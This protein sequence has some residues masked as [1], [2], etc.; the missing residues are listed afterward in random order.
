MSNFNAPVHEYD[1]LVRHVLAR[2]IQLLN[3][4]VNLTEDFKLVLE[5][6]G[7]FVDEQ[8]LP[9]ALSADEQGCTIKGNQAF[10]PDGYK[11]AYQNYIQDGWG[12][13]HTSVEDGGQGLPLPLSFACD[14]VLSSG[15]MAFALYI[16][17]RLGVYEVIKT[18]GSDYLKQKYLEKI[19]TGVWNG[20]MCL[21]EPQC[22]TDLS[23]IKTKAVL[24]EDGTYRLSGTKIF[25][26]GGDHHLTDNIVHLVLARI[27]GAPTGLAG[28]GLFIVPKY[29][30]NDGEIGDSNH[31]SCARLENKLGI[32]ASATAELV[33]DQAQGWI[34]GQPG[35]GLLGMFSMMKLARIGTSFQALGVAEYTYQKAVDYAQ[36][37]IQG[38]DLINKSK[39]SIA[40][41]QHPNIRRELLRMQTSISSGRLLAF[42]TTLLNE[43]T[44]T[45][46]HP[47]L[48]KLANAILPI[49]M[50]VSKTVCSEYGVEVATAAMQTYGGHG[51]IHESGIEHALRDVQILP[52]YEGTNDVQSLDIILRRIFDGKHE[53]VSILLN[54]LEQQFDDLELN[55]C[56]QI[57]LE[58]SKHLFEQL[59]ETTESIKDNLQQNPFAALQYA[60]DYLWYVAHSMMSVLWLRV[61]SSLTHSENLAVNKQNKYAEAAFYFNYMQIDTFTRHERLKRA[62][63]MSAV[64][65]NFQPEL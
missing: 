13:I 19:G 38:R 56:D 53:T 41:I 3:Y 28:L 2:E 12:A 20:T 23:L 55:E 27:E 37:R 34:V 33:F 44:T 4:D 15:S 32:H 18:L 29:L 60:K 25:I 9:L 5:S 65:Q 47:E 59:K 40:I 36:N 43:L 31:V 46:D 48:K 17:I 14:E 50:A 58:Q 39:D 42:Q 16:S 45:S 24:N 62:N 49:F 51:Y 10:A 8:L 63:A 26:T 61:I 52:I 1:F 22:G 57:Y 30:S 64:L 11:E 54:W 35:Q 7:T 6:V 21:T